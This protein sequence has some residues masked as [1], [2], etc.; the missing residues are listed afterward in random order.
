MKERDIDIIR[1]IAGYCNDISETISRFGNTLDDLI[2]DKDY[3]YSVSLS[4]FQIT[5]LTTKLSDDFTSEYSTEPWR[6]M[7]G[8][9][10]FFAHKYGKLD[11]EILYNTITTKVPDLLVF[12][13]NVLEDN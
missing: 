8:M 6:E 4:T 9:R 2:A 3:R 13:N 1:H 12:C 10:K 7:R 11:V 5:E